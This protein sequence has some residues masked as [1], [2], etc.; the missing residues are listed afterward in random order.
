MGDCGEQ[1][2]PVNEGTQKTVADWARDMI[3]AAVNEIMDRGVFNSEIIEARPVW[4]LPYQLVIGQVR[5]PHEQLESTWIIA[6]SVPTDHVS[7]A[8]APTPREAARH[9]AM[10]WQLDAARYADPSV[11]Q[12]LGAGNTADWERMADVLARTAETL[13]G[14]A[15]DDRHWQPRG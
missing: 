13:A 5:E 6:G 1:G 8:A 7:A 9:F 10:K 12:E 2:R 15:A 3:D 4:W 11:Q 14:L